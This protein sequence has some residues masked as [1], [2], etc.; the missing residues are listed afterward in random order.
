MPIRAGPP[1]VDRR[2]PLRKQR[3]DDTGQHVARSGRR[4]CRRAAR[5]EV[6]ARAICNEGGS[7]FQQRRDSEFVDE[8]P[9]PRATLSRRGRT[10]SGDQCK[11]TLVRR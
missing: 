4:Q 11:L 6:Q 10:E 8:R 3:R 1:G 2:E 9:Q 7:A 5:T